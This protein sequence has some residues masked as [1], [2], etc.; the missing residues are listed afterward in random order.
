[1]SIKPNFPFYGDSDKTELTYSIQEYKYDDRYNR[2]T[3]TISIAYCQHLDEYDME[4]MK[5]GVAQFIIIEPLYSLEGKFE[6]RLTPVYAMVLKPY[7][8]FGVATTMYNLAESITGFKVEND[9]PL[10]SKDG[11]AFWLNRGGDE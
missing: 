7:R 9:S 11:R 6:G 5:Y 8:R 1:M 4:P 10:Q 2:M 3:S